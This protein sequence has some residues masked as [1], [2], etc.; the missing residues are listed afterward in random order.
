MGCSPLLVGW[1]LGCASDADVHEPRPQHATPAPLEPLTP[2]AAGPFLCDPSQVPS[3]QPLRRLSSTQYESRLR[4]LVERVAPAHSAAILGELRHVVAALPRDL[5]GGPEPDYGGLRRL[6]QSIYAESVDGSYAV[7]VALGAALTSNAERLRA[8]AGEC[9]VDADA[10]NDSAC[11]ETFVQRLGELVFRRP[12]SA[13]DRAFYREAAD[14]SDIVTLLVSS[15]FFLYTV[16]LGELATAHELA[17][18]LALHFWQGAPDAELIAA[19]E[20]GELLDADHYA[21]QVERVY[22]DAKTERMLEELFIDWLEPKHLEELHL[23]VGS[24]D[25]DALRGDFTPGPELKSRMLR[26]LGRMGV[27]YAHRTNSTFAELFLSRSSFAETADLAEIYGVPV[28]D[29]AG[30]PPTFPDPER[31]GLLT[32][33]ALVATGHGTSHPIFK[34][35]YARKTV[36]CETIP[37][38]PAD[39]NVVAMAARPAN[40]TSRAV[41]EAL[42]GARADCAACHASLINPVGFT[43]E[44]F[45]GLGRFRALE[46]VFDPLSGAL[47]TEEPVDSKAVPRVLPDD[48]REAQGAADLHRFMLESG[49]PQLCFA[50]RY[51]R[52]T[53]ARE[54][55][56]ARDGCVLNALLQPLLAGE[57]LKTA[58]RAVALQPAFRERSLEP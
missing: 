6:D 13:E 26:E 44:H 5:R 15:P 28:W 56:E 29:G 14:Y 49:K 27:Y 16:E 58:L 45:D 12:L 11:V 50:R 32:R 18:R 52:Y 35:V 41:T 22:A 30:E 8:L 17:A 7:A 33:A 9:A 1:A 46:R 51:F 4:E 48:A 31:V 47:I 42:S 2:A 40:R 20:S 10:G 3:Q 24:F 37:P 38:P 19:A 21:Q 23:R 43:L 39:A 53:F 54:E 34:G 25:Y 57:S 36:L 55:D